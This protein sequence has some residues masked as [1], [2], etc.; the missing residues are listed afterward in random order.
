MKVNTS[1]A[2]RR[3][4]EHKMIKSA[5]KEAAHTAADIFGAMV[6]ANLETKTALLAAVR[7]YFKVGEKRMR[8]FMAFL[9]EVEKEYEGYQYD[10][11]FEY[12]ARQ[13]FGA[14]NIDIKAEMECEDSLEQ[15][16]SLY[17]RSVE[18]NLTNREAEFM[19]EQLN[20]FKRFREEQSCG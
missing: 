15:A 17:V 19:Q 16:V 10:D 5:Q 20:A 13:E 11:V 2:M 8:E 18:P 6:Y 3:Q 14:I 12:K 7:R 9:K 1:R 4:Q